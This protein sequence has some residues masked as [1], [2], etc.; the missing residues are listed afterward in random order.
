MVSKLTQNH[1]VDY[2]ILSKNVPSRLPE[3]LADGAKIIV[4]ENTDI[5]ILSSKFIKTYL[6]LS[7]KYL[8]LICTIIRFGKM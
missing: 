2:V 7:L 8:Q 1:G 5:S 6:F 4:T 3:L